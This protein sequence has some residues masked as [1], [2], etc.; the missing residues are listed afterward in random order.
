V[1]K[2]V[3][4]AI[5][6]RR[7]AIRGIRGIGDAFAHL[8]VVAVA[9]AVSLLL[10]LK[11][12]RLVF[13]WLRAVKA[14]PDAPSEEKLETIV[15]RTDAV[16]LLGRPL[17]RSE[18]LSRSCVLYYQMR[19]AGANV[20]IR[21]GVRNDGQRLRFHSWVLVDGAP[22]YEHFDPD[23]EYKGFYNLLDQKAS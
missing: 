12:S 7:Q 11:L 4:A 1:V 20:D 14:G 15:R 2:R 3:K 9:L 8:P 19:R 6:R 18:C 17:I 13:K 21:I 23:V 16:L 10:R 22:T 5:A